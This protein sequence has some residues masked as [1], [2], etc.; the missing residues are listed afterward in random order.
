MKAKGINPDI[1]FLR[2]YPA[3][4]VY[5]CNKKVLSLQVKSMVGR[6]VQ[7]EGQRHKPG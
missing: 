7:D 6:D 4:P 3:Y 1:W 2:F 5:P